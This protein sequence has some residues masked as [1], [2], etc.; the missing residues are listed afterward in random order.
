MSIEQEGTVTFALS[1]AHADW[2]TNEQGYR[3]APVNSHG[4]TV[5]ASKH[6]DKTVEVRISG[7][8]RQQF[9]FRRP[10][11]ASTDTGVVVAITWQAGE[12]KLYLNGELADTITARTPHD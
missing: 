8:F 9:L 3:F 11:P 12:V 10:V 1:H 2:A 7:P 4:V 5:E 6:P